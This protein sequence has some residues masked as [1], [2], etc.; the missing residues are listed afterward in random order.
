MTETPTPEPIAALAWCPFPSV[1]TAQSAANTLLDEALI[2]CANILPEMLSMFEW[3]GERGSERE[4]GALFKTHADLLD[5]MIERLG[6]LHP[7]ETPAIIGWS[8]DSAH[9]STQTWIG[10]LIAK[11]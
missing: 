5:R 4:V 11:H 2:V 9:P 6:E 3:G 7:Y 10:G 1:E 8:C